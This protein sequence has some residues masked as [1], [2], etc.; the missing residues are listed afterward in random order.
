[1]DIN[2]ART[3]RQIIALMKLRGCSEEQIMEVLYRRQP[4]LAR[5]GRNQGVDG[6]AS[7]VRKPCIYEWVVCFSM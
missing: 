2:E 3:Q 1:M 6:G 4:F 5:V 7:S